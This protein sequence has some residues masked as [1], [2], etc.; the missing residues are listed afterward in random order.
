MAENKVTA[1]DKKVASS[2]AKSVETKVEEVVEKAADAVKTE[3][4]KVE[5]KAAPI[6]K[7]AAKTA[8]TTTTK[9]TKAAT[10]KADEVKTAAKEVKEEVAKKVTAKKAAAK[11]KKVNI[12]IQYNYQEITEEALVGRIV[13]KWVK[14]TGKKESSIKDFDVYIKPEDN[15]AYYVINGQG[16]SIALF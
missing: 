7:K 2:E 10:K 15:A 11:Q 6:V 16:S 12:F 4:K 1:T 8:K 9:A 3:A 5:E 14:E 13:D